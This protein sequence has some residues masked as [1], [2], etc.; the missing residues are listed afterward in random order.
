MQKLTRLSLL[1][2]SSAS[3]STDEAASSSGF[4]KTLKTCKA[5]LGVSTS[6]STASTSKSNAAETIALNEDEEDETR[7][8]SD[9]EEQEDPADYCKGGYHPI[10]IG[11]VFEG[12][13]NVIRKLGWGHFSTVWLC[14]DSQLKRF[15]ALKVV[16]SA[17]HY[18]E[19]ALDEIKLLRCVRESDPTDPSGNKVVQLLDD[20]KISG[21]NG[22]HVCMVFEVLGHNLLKLILRS[23]YEGIPLMNVKTIVRQVLQGLHYLH[24]KCHIIHTD[25]KPE[26]ILVTVTEEHI[27]RLAYEAAQWQK[28]GVRMP[29]SLVSTAPI[30]Y[31]SGVVTAPEKTGEP[32]SKTKKRRMKKKAKKQQQQLHQQLEQQLVLE[33]QKAASTSG[34]SLLVPGQ[35]PVNVLPSP[36]S[37]LPT[38]IPGSHTVCGPDMSYSP[39]RVM[40]MPH[41][42]S[43]SPTPPGLVAGRNLSPHCYET[44]SSF[45]SPHSPPIPSSPSYLNGYSSGGKEV[46]FLSGENIAITGPLNDDY[47]SLNFCPGATQHHQQ[48]QPPHPHV[49]PHHRLESSHSFVTAESGAHPKDPISLRRVASCPGEN[50]FICVTVFLQSDYPAGSPSLS[51]RRKSLS[52]CFAAFSNRDMTEGSAS[53]HFPSLLS[54]FLP[55]NVAK[56]TIRPSICV[57]LSPFDPLSLPCA[58]FLYARSTHEPPST[59]KPYAFLFSPPALVLHVSCIE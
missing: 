45:L 43:P 20:F 29:I 48:Q 17:C 26:N 55:R 54:L 19:T 28:M 33:A 46:R 53:P 56:Q 51:P 34:P 40:G 31:A 27:A 24:T 58:L 22:T 39:T 59:H 52:T 4:A 6:S 2:S 49:Q 42:S 30:E 38:L 15:V 3:S 8:E 25:I 44:S 47:A 21:I 50:L 18:T 36:A 10:R 13:Y 23:N 9:D 57:F 16:K 1:F 14:W 12:R 41:R 35:V 32:M 5:A 7:K 37:P 11:D